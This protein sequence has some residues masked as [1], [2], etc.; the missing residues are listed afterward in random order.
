MGNAGR[1]VVSVGLAVLAGGWIA[2]GR[3]DTPPLLGW[4]A[5]AAL[6][7][8]GA[9]WVLQ[10]EPRAGVD[11][12][13]R[14]ARDFTVFAAV[15]IGLA[16]AALVSGVAVLVGLAALGVMIGYSR[17]VERRGPFGYLALAALAGLPFTYGA[18]AVGRA[19]GGTVP[20]ILA[21][22]PG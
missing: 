8:T 19:A 17:V 20:W 14:G 6:G 13:G 7:L 1:L 3:L 15:L 11:T 4:A 12:L 9:G 21:A 5:V 22:W 10:G 16:G 2:L 18:L